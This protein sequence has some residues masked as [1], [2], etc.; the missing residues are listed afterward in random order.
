MLILAGR[1]SNSSDMITHELF[2]LPSIYKTK[3]SNIMTK[4]KYHFGSEDYFVF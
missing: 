3:L 2:I 4:F 1:S